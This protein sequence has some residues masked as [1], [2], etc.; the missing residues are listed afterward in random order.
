MIIQ[1]DPVK[2]YTVL[3][4]AKVLKSE[5][6]ILPRNLFQ[7]SAISSVVGV[8][9]DSI[10][11][12]AYFENLTEPYYYTLWDSP[13]LAYIALL[14][15]DIN[16]LMQAHKS[17]YSVGVFENGKLV[18]ELTNPLLI[19]THDYVVAG[20]SISIAYKLEEADTIEGGSNNNPQI[21]LI[22][23]EPLMYKTD[24]MLQ[25]AANST[26]VSPYIDITSN[27]SF[28][29]IIQS[30]SAMGSVIWKPEIPELGNAVYDYI[31]SI[32]VTLLNVSKGDTVLFTI[33]DRVPNRS[34][35]N[36]IVQFK[37]IK[38]K[39]K[40]TLRYYLMMLKIG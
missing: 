36:F 22:Q 20:K 39:K 40:C 13:A 35:Y 14:S 38:P 6:V 27:E 2:L 8:S 15:K 7:D 25:A 9:Y 28:L 1:T 32:P 31:M 21:P 23:Y 4:A 16:A 30:K 24:Y 3:E 18:S 11:T 33:L 37:V 34:G 5:Y 29:N 17:K 19:Y 10:I 12:L 26:P